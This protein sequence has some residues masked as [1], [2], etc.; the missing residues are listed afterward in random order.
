MTVVAIYDGVHVFACET[1]IP[2][3]SYLSIA[4]RSLRTTPLES[5]Y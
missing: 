5:A 2:I 3:L 1:R 4:K